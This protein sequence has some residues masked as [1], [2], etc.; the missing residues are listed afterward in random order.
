MDP[1]EEVQEQQQPK[2]HYTNHNGVLGHM[3][4][5]GIGTE[6]FAFTIEDNLFRL[7][8][9]MVE[10]DPETGLEVNPAN[11]DIDAIAFANPLPPDFKGTPDPRMLITM[12]DFK[13]TLKSERDYMANYVREQLEDVGGGGSGDKPDPTSPTNPVTA[14]LQPTMFTVDMLV[15]ELTQILG[16]LPM[17]TFVDRV[18]LETH[19]N[20]TLLDGTEDEWFFSIGTA[21]PTEA[22]LLIP[23]TPIT[24]LNKR[25][26]WVVDVQ[27]T[28]ANPTAFVLY[29]YNV[30]EENPNPLPGPVEPEE[31]DPDGD[32]VQAVFLN[33]SEVT[34]GLTSDA[35]K[36][37]WNLTVQSDDALPGFDQPDLFGE[38]GDAQL[39]DVG[40][41]M[42]F[43]P[44]H[45]YRVLQQ[46]P[47]LVHFSMDP[48]VEE[49]EGVWTK[50]ATYD[51]NPENPEEEFRYYF[52]MKPSAGEIDYLH[53]FVYDLDGET[54]EQVCRT[55][56]IRNLVTFRDIVAPPPPVMDTF[57][58]FAR[59]STPDIDVHIE[60]DTETDCTIIVSG[61]TATGNI[62]HPELFGD[63]SGANG[64]D[65]EI[66]L[67]IEIGAT[68]MVV[69]INK[70]LEI[71]KDDPSISSSPDGNVWVKQKT[72]TR[73]ND[74]EEFKY[75]FVLTERVEEEEF[76]TIALFNEGEENPF[77]TY[78]I[79]NEIYFATPEIPQTFA[80]R[81]RAA[82]MALAEEG[83]EESSEKATT[84]T[85]K[86]EGACRIR[87]L[88]F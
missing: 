59:A 42:P 73:E 33:H 25:R 34:Y 30:T 45:R 82:V 61:S 31:P 39:I 29:I 78:T 81:R 80:M 74:G 69:Q 79:K 65:I 53:L 77:K 2:I 23:K 68:V 22:E 49:V 72:Y 64:I 38:I 6:S 37:V 36:K 44:G 4:V 26:A 3:F 63:L 8:K 67:P 88:S 32:F 87:I 13:A 28:F 71:F 60:S 46:N 58:Q 35:S 52:C 41:N 75:C 85:G 84:S 11:F 70:A 5:I 12:Q 7:F 15:P 55:Y 54:P 9:T 86:D 40:V 56:H 14:M 24:E 21:D 10:T 16:T 27:R 19:T 51:W 76:V 83:D 48:R 47:A 57:E 1:T 17:Q 20:F 43:K 62:S 50:F 18:V 66:N